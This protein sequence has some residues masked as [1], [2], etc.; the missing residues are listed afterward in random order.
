MTTTITHLHP[1]NSE[2][3]ER[4]LERVPEAP[5]DFDRAAMIEQ[6][7]MILTGALDLILEDF[8]AKPGMAASSAIGC[9]IIAAVIDRLQD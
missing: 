2:A 6:L 7:P 8:E 9:R 4:L 5:A 3:R 1:G